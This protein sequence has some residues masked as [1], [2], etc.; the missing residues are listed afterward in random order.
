MELTIKE[1]KNCST[2]FYVGDTIKLVDKTEIT[3]IYIKVSR[4]HLCI[5]QDRSASNDT[6]GKKI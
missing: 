1:C 2:T 4:C 5:N 6:L 3:H